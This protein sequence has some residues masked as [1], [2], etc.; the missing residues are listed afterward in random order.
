LPDIAVYVAA[1]TYGKEKKTMSK[2]RPSAFVL[3]LTVMG[4]TAM[5][6]AEG[7][8]W[9]YS[10]ETGPEN[11]GKLDAGYVACETG[12][13]QSPIDLVNLVDADLQPIDFVYKPG[14]T[15]II[16]NGHTIQVNYAAGSSITVDGRA[17]ELK[18]FHFHAPS[19][20][21]INGKHFP[22]EGHLVHADKDGNLAVVAVM[23]EQTRNSPLLSPLWMKMPDNAGDR[24]ALPK[25]YDVSAMLPSDRDYYRFDGSLTT[26]PCSEGVLWFVLK[27][28]SIASKPQID[29]FTEVMGHPNNRPVQPLNARQVLK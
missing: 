7:A 9:G 18:Q 28:P 17:F 26:P 12:K 15:E 29:R 19:E 14:T 22:L 16:N 2:I 4:V 6:R 11:W 25:M 24:N 13:K 5:A 21:T 1:N 23:F 10:G 8:G 20:N 3:G 27:Q